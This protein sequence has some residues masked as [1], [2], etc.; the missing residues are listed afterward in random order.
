ME[1]EEISA[2]IENALNEV[3]PE[4]SDYEEGDLLVDWAVITYVTNPNEEKQSG[5]PMLFANG[6][7][8]HYRAL[9]LLTVALEFLKGDG[10][11]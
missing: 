3:L 11:E 7:M 2:V 1:A 5:Y 6:K 10:P 8:A 9:G 4:M